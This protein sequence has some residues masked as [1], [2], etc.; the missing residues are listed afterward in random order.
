[1]E[2]FGN[3]EITCTS[4]NCGWRGRI[5]KTRL[6]RIMPFDWIFSPAAT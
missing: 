1:M 4:A 3:E 5:S 6:L 2:M